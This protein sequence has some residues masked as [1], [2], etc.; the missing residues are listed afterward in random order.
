M[1]K[2]A[3]LSREERLI[4][5][6][7]VHILQSDVYFAISIFVRANREASSIFDS[8]ERGSCRITS[9]DI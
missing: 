9:F 5:L 4:T 6:S 1:E 8:R 2:K 3:M 7:T